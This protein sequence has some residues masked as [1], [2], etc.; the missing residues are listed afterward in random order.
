MGL[1]ISLQ[2]DGISLLRDKLEK[3]IDVGTKIELC[4][5]LSKQYES[6]NQDST[7]YFLNQ[8]LDL[9]S[10][11]QFVAQQ[12]DISSRLGYYFIGKNS[13]DSAKV[14]YS[15][16]R[17]LYHQVDSTYLFTKNTMLLGNINLAQNN[18]LSALEYYQ[19][20]LLLARTSN[21]DDLLP[22]L[23]NNMGLLYKEIEDYDDALQSFDK[24]YKLFIDQGDEANSVYP[25]Y[26]IALINSIQGDDE[27]AIEGY[28]NL[29]SYHLKNENWLSLAAIYNSVSEIYFKNEDLENANKFLSMSLNALKNKTDSFNSGP[30][31][32]QEGAVYSNAAEIYAYSEQTRLA[33]V[34]A[35]KSLK[36]SL[37]NSYKLYVFRSS[38]V[39]ADIYDAE[40]Q[41]DSALY[42][43]KLYTNYNDAYQDES[44]IKQL[45]MLKMQNE[46]DEILRQKEIERIYREAEYKNR[47]LKFT[48]FLIAVFLIAI[49]LVLLYVNQKNK[50][51]K[52][53][54]KEENLLLE[55]KQLEKDLDYK[56]KELVSNLMYLLEKNEFITSISKKLIE[57]KPDAKKDNKDII[58]Q[59]INEIR[60][61]SSQQ[62][63]EEFEL[64]FKEVHMDFYD[65]LNDAH[66][67]LTPN[68]IKICA[69][70][71]LNM[72]TKEISAITHQSVKSINMA[73]FR[74]RKK[75]D[76]DRDENLISYLNSL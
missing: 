52:L 23:N 14:Y 51:A 62:V 72:S 69:F 1:W 58:Q 34:Y 26:N 24:A 21:F 19:E 29:T 37:P 31:S 76:I 15:M 46:F 7:F 75:L 22:H 13:M 33:K 43:Y 56:K 30:V 49:I 18:H 2:T 36:V 63:W 35:H 3:S 67:D 64:R 32:L 65:S 47:E 27:A 59:I 10:K 74:L 50:N 28:L 71:R 39:L 17:D 73:R 48:G 9:S 54:L 68:E 55:K 11:S 8:A 53:K 16:A 6:I 61:N 66:P 41:L 40:K 5:D 60:V 12:A 38:K 42:F 70:L 45:T 25:L 4:L 20:S 44:D 57:L